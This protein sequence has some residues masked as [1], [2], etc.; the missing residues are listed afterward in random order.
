MP[1]KVS[2]SCGKSFAAPDNLAGKKVKCPNCQIPLAIPGA[3]A[4]AAAPAP[5]PTLTN[6]AASMF[7]EAGMSAAPVGTIACPGC[8]APLSPGVVLCIKCGFNLKLGKKMGTAVV[9]AHSGGGGHGGHGDVA[10]TLLA[11]AADSLEAD[12]Q[13]EIEKTS[14]GMPWWVYLIAL[15]FAVGFMIGMTM[16]P[17]HQ[18]M[19]AGAGFFM[20]AGAGAAFFGWLRVIMA[21]F[22][23]STLQGVLCL[24]GGPYWVIY[25]FM[26]WDKC[27]GPFMINFLGNAIFSAGIGMIAL[28]NYFASGGGEDSSIPRKPAYA[29][30]VAEESTSIAPFMAT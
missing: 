27:S 7:D 12:R 18:A 4:P 29:M 2:C 22:E 30:V 15:K 9:G 20:F 11:R 21:A 8:T 17:K 19:Y 23:D 5:L 25:S 16:L 1:I 26:K 3:T 13:A 14:S 10:A 6:T 28:G 24:C